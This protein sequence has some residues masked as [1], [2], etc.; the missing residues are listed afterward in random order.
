MARRRWRPRLR[1]TEPHG[2]D[3]HG[4]WCGL[5]PGLCP[6]ED[7]RWAAAIARNTAWRYGEA[8]A[9]R[10]WRRDHPDPDSP[11]W[12]DIPDPVGCSENEESD[13]ERPDDPPRHGANF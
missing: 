9:D 2:D 5:V 13:E 1:R 6:V 8:A 11:D 4:K 12:R 10:N 3:E 7:L